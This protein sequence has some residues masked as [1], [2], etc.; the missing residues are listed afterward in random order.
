[1]RGIRAPLTIAEGAGEDI[2]GGN[3]FGQGIGSGLVGDVGVTAIAVQ[4]ERAIGAD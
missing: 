4:L 1:M 2:D 3:A